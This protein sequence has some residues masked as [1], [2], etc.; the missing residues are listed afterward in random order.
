[1]KHFAHVLTDKLIKWKIVKDEDRE[2]YVYGFWQGAILVFNFATVVIIGLLFNMMW[3]SLVFTVAYGLL[4]TA[5][6][7]YHAR[8][9]RNCYFLSIMLIVAVL[10]TLKWLP[11]NNLTC[12]AFLI[13][14]AF[15]VFFLA[16]VED[17]NKPLDELE[18]KVYKKRSRIISLLLSILTILFIGAGQRQIANCIAISILASTIMLILG[19]VKI[20]YN[21]HN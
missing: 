19:K 8:T 5:A 14:S 11:W 2:I 20:L 4:R 13:L 12:I 10:C 3:Q 15:I 18:Q 7:G 17:Q 1:M 9:Q 6:G 21:I 16:P